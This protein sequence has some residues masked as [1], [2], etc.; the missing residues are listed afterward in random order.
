M[1]EWHAKARDKDFGKE[2]RRQEA[3]IREEEK[4]KG[5]TWSLYVPGH[6]TV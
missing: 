6:G 5:K 4:T 2:R 1:N 3:Q